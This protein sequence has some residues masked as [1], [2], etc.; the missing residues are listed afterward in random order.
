MGVQ[1][2]RETMIDELIL[3]FISSLPEILEGNDPHTEWY[4]QA[5]LELYAEYNR[6]DDNDAYISD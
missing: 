1:Q 5:H 4:K 6:G 3:E 2:R